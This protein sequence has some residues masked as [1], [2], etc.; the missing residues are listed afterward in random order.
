MEKSYIKKTQT[1]FNRKQNY[2]PKFEETSGTHI[3][4]PDSPIPGITIC[5]F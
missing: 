5:L 2:I 4:R 1:Y 3:S